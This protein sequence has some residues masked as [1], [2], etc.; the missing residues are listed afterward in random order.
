FLR[1][2]KISWQ[3][4]GADVYFQIN[5]AAAGGGL[6]LSPYATLDFRVDRET[7]KRTALNPATATNFHVQLVAADGSLSA[8]V[9]VSDFIEVIG[10]FG[11]PDADLTFIGPNFPDGYH[12]NLPTA[13][14][15]MDAFSFEQV[16]QTRGIRLTFDNTATGSV[17]VTNFRGSRQGIRSIGGAGSSI[18]GAEVVLAAASSNDSRRVIEEGNVIEDVDTATMKGGTVRFTLRTEKPILVTNELITLSVGSIVCDGSYL[19]GSTQRM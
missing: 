4:A 17:Y 7:P 15:P 2:G 16:G 6:D 8:P 13:R 11:T 10:P 18:A 12:V 5:F 3:R 14:I 1:A 9:A 19:D